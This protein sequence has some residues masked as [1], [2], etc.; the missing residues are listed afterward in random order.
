MQILKKT[1][2]IL[3]SPLGIMTI[4]L[5]G[6]MILAFLRRGAR[7]STRLLAG[8][9]ALFIVFTF[10]PLAEILIRSLERPY[11][12]LL[13]PPLASSIRLIVVLANYGENHLT[14]PV[15]SNV[16]SETACRLA[17]GIRLHRLLPG[18]KL[19][20]SGG[21]LREQDPSVA[22]IMADY[23]RQLG[24]AD[25]DIIVEEQST[26]TYENLSGIA[27]VAGSDPF[28]LV[29]SGCHLR[30][31]LAV[32]GK[33]GLKPIAAPAC[34]WTLQSYPAEMTWAE[35]G[36]AVLGGF[37]HPSTDRWRY[38]QWA[39]HEYVGYFWYKMLGRI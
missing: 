30:R 13:N 32:A 33:M 6:G 16:S 37:A 36:G 18:S 3:L 11:P 29:T 5:A 10:S 22:A 28:I 15:T 34:I 8:G 17:E 23:V 20:L 35:W 21:V 7:W 31:T 4:L 14:I 39:Y 1:V 25:S 9:A 24:V 2:E 26:T 19:V 12:P 27:K 38:L